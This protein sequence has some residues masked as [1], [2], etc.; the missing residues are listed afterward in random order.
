MAKEKQNTS[1]IMMIAPVNFG[2]NAQT[3]ES[4]AFQKATQQ[5]TVQEQA[6]QEFNALVDLLRANGIQVWVVEDTAAPHT[7]D[8][9][10]PNNWFSTHSNSKVAIYPMQAENRRQERRADIISNLAEIF[11]I[12]DIADYTLAE[13]EGKYLEGTGSMV[14]DRENKIC[15]ASISLRTDT[16]LVN[17]FCSDFDY[18]PVLFDAIDQNGKPIYHTNVVMSVGHNFMV[19][20]LACIANPVQQQ[21]IKEIAGKEIIEISIDQMEAFAGNMLEMQNEDGKHLLIMS[22]RA[23]QCLLPAQIEQLSRHAVLLNSPLNT[24]EDNGGGSARCMMAE[25]FLP[26]K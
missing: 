21:Q 20:C 11:S 18:R 7:P 17:Q 23:Y 12:V 10:F 8:S 9:I 26:K 13:R 22:S 16:D 19:I 2:Y 14:L 24:I 6:L 1:H 25:I 4:N 3:A 5:H 15:Y